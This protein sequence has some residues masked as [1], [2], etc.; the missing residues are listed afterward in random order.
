ML[1]EFLLASY[2][3]ANEIGVPTSTNNIGA[4][5]TNGTKLLMS[6]MGGLALIALIWGAIQMSYSRGNPAGVHRARETILYACVGL[7]VA[8]AAFAIV[9]FITT[10]VK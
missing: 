5:I 7:I 2:I 10:K 8:I 1:Q 6:V 4:A 3:K 9:T